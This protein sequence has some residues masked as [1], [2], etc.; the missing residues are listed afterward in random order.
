M[1]ADAPLVSDKKLALEM[2]ESMLRTEQSRLTS[3]EEKDNYRGVKAT[4]G[5]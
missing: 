4:S 1:D 5:F 3:T 2:Y